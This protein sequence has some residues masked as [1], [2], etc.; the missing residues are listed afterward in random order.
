MLRRQFSPNL[1]YIN[2]M[3]SQPK[4][5]QFCR[6]Q[7]VNSTMYK[8]GRE[9]GKCFKNTLEKNKVGY[10]TLPDYKT[11]YKVTVIEIVWYIG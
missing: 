6:Y 10:L 4:S 5:W 7:Q 9:L 8:E 1:I 3:L 11:S 2:S